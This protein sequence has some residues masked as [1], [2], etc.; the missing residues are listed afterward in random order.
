[1][2]TELSLTLSSQVMKPLIKIL[3]AFGS[4]PRSAEYFI[5]RLN[6][7]NGFTLFILHF[8]TAHKFF[9]WMTVVKYTESIFAVFEQLTLIIRTAAVAITFDLRFSKYQNIAKLFEEISE[10]P[11]F[12]SDHR[13]IKLQKRIKV[14]II[15]CWTFIAL[16]VILAASFMFHSSTKDYVNWLFYGDSSDKAPDA[17]IRLVMIADWGL[18]LFLVICNECFSQAFYVSLCFIVREKILD[19]NDFL[20]RLENKN[21]VKQSQQLQEL[22]KLHSRL[23]YIIE[24]MEDN[25]SFPVFNSILCIIFNICVKIESIISGVRNAEFTQFGYIFLDIFYYIFIFVFICMTASEIGEERTEPIVAV[26]KMAENGD[27]TDWAFQQESQLLLTK[28][29]TRMLRLTGWGCFEINKSFMLTILGAIAT[30]TILIL[31]MD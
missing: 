22:Y 4:W 1:M 30:Y 11:L 3:K 10:Y 17:V 8:Y 21:M 18:Y 7:W 31:Q 28:L 19:Y 13:L 2:R 23:S 27:I 15:V 29:N 5:L 26:T 24:L 16:H 20:V 12:N 25:F 6:P 9:N 14:I